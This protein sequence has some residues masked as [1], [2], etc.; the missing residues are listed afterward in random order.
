MRRWFLSYH[1]PDQP[2]AEQLKGAIEREDEGVRVFF[3]PTSLRVGGRW[4][5]ALAEALAEAAAFVMLVTDTG[6]GPWQQIEYE[7]ALDKHVNSPD[8]PIILMLLEGQAVPRLSFLKQFHWIVAPD[9][10]SSK[11]VTRLIEAVASGHDAKLGELWRYTSPYRGLSAMEES[12]A[13]YFFGRERETVEVVRT[14]AAESNRLPVLLGN[15]GVGK[16]SLAQAGVMATL[17]RQAWFGR[18]APYAWPAAFS[19]SR[20]WFFVTLKPGAD[21]IRALVESFMRRWQYDVTDPEWE[22]RRQGWVDMLSDA[23]ATLP[24]LLDATERRYEQLGLPKPPA[25][26]LYI[27]QGEEL[28]TR[29]EEVLRRRFAKL[30]AD[31]VAD[32]RF[33]AL[34]S[35]RS[36][37]LGALQNDDNLFLVHRKIDVP[38]LREDDLRRVITEPARQ[39]G[40]R[41]ESEE[42][43]EMITRR[44]VEDSAKDVGALPLLSYTIDDMWTEM[45]RRGDGVLRVS[46]TV[47]ELG[48]VL[49]DRAN[50]FIARNP[51]AEDSLRGLLTL[52]LA[53][54]REDGEPTRRRALRSEFTDEEWRLIGELADHPN[55]LLVTATPEASEPYAE[56]AHE[57]IFRRWQKLRDWIAEEREFLIWRNGL[58]ASYRSWVMVPEH[59]REI[60]LLMGHALAQAE[61]WLRSRAHDLPSTYRDFIDRSIRR[62][63]VELEQRQRLII[64]SELVEQLLAHF[65][66]ELATPI[67]KLSSLAISN[68]N[69][70][71]KA[72]R[73]NPDEADN[74]RILEESKNVIANQTHDIATRMKL[75][76]AL[77]EQSIG[78]IDVKFELFQW[79]ALISG[80]ESD[81][82]AW[83][84]TQR[85]QQGLGD[86]FIRMDASLAQLSSV[87]D[88]DLIGGIL[89][90]LLK[91]AL[92]YSLPPSTSKP[93]EVRIH[94]EVRGDIVHIQIENWGIGISRDQRELIFQKFYRGPGDGVRA[95]RGMGLGLYI[96]RLYATLHGGELVCLSSRPTLADQDR[97]RSLEG[98]ST[99]FELK[100]PK[101]ERLGVHRIPVPTINT[102][103]VTS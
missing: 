8:F 98:F 14:L 94:G 9:L 16:S 87:G 58:E 99:I 62:Q 36:D 27:D 49:A 76:L 23:R 74:V 102:S 13:D 10:T 95:R 11:E 48:G 31:A 88:R 80:V 96:S 69:R 37:F 45:V 28:Y 92:Q 85:K 60:A 103:G 82:L 66:H 1:S 86:A 70:A 97:T 56:V 6:I 34:M 57:A 75:I 91:N 50:S 18:T 64:S 15:S 26:L 24:G 20:R 47:F 7:A 65:G 89:T 72:L 54:V 19:N 43:I 17:H 71:I 100:L 30:V 38:P 44:T 59:S 77:H 84:A 52:K 90:N 41:F 83:F 40:A 39:L 32:P 22:A 81:V 12:D 101:I 68:I 79:R 4:A 93:I 78:K 42:L 33:V 2:L 73:R 29:S 67:A 25:F 55:R 21:P 51:A 5:P 53:T 46:A 35:L 3:A 63:A 61:G